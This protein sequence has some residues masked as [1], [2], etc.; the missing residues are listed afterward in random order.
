[1]YAGSKQKFL[2][3]VTGRHD[4]PFYY[5]EQVDMQRSFLDAFLKGQDSL[6]WSMRGKLSPV[7]LV[8]REGSPGYNDAEAE[9]KR[10]PRRVEDEWPIARTSYRKLHLTGD[11]LLDESTPEA[12]ATVLSYDA[13]E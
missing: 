4:L 13:P 10:F 1:M 8:L 9:R 12:Q 6:G 2:R 11:A 3:C 5:E 7:E